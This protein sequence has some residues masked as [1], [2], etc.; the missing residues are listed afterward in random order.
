MPLEAANVQLGPGEVTHAR[1]APVRISGYFGQDTQYRRS[2]FLIG[3]PVGLAVTGAA[4]LAHNASK[5]AE[6]ERA[7]K[8]SWHQLGTAEVVVTNQRLVATGS[9]R[10]ESLWYAEVGPAAARSWSGRRARRAVPAVEP[11][12]AQARGSV[13]A[14]ALRVRALPRRRA[15]SGRPD[16]RRAARAC[17]A[18][19]PAPLARSWCREEDSRPPPV[20]RCLVSPRWRRARSRRTSCCRSRCCRT[21]CCRSRCCRTSCCRTRCCRTS[22]CRTRCC[23]S[24]SCRS[25][26]C[27]TSVPPVPTRCCR[28]RCRP[29]RS[30]QPPRRRHR[31]RGERLPEDVLLAAAGRRRRAVR[32]S[33]PRAMLERA[34]A[35]RRASNF[36]RRRLAGV[37]VASV[38]LD[39]AGALRLVVG[40]ADRLRRCR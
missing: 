10:T 27:R 3:G 16:A 31:G 26:C 37:F 30:C 1:I 23:R 28:S 36:W 15:G 34:G 32:W 9:G 19:G 33:V 25:R 24:R 13:G 11:A 6:A 2:F 5:K 4:S 8:P 20:C 21:S 18:A 38:E 39:L 17:P 35:L 14:A 7:A 29:T 40:P 12:L 22:C